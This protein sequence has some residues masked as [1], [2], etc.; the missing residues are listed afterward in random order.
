M[1]FLAEEPT[2]F[3]DHAEKEL[4]KDGMTIVIAFSGAQE[5]VVVTGWRWKKK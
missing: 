4:T 3:S 2:F 5:L 1:K